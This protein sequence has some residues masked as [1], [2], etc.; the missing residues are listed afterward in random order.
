MHLITVL[1]RWARGDWF[2]REAANRQ[3]DYWTEEIWLSWIRDLLFGRRCQ[4]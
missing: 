4:H 3:D 2:L 1:Q